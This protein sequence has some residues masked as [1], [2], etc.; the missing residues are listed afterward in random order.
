M[1]KGDIIEI[2]ITDMTDDGKGVGHFD[3][4]AVFTDGAVIGDTV[5]A[6][7]NK[8][9]KNYSFASCLEIIEQSK[10]RRKDPCPYIKTCGGCAYGLL[11]HDAQLELKRSHVE[12][13]LKRLGGIA[14]PKV[15]EIVPSD[16]PFNY[17]NKAVMAVS[18]EAVGFNAR[19]SHDVTDCLDCELQASPAMAAASSLRS[20]IK[21]DHIKDLVNRLTVK[22]AFDTGEVM[23]IFDIKSKGIPNFEKLVDI[24]DEA[25]SDLPPNEG[26][27]YS[28]ESV[29]LID[30]NGKCTV[31]AG[32][33]T[34]KDVICGLTFEISPLSFYQ[35][36]PRQAE[37]LYYKVA[38][39]AHIKGGENILDLYCGVGTIGLVL[40]A[41]QEDKLG[42][43]VGVESVHEAVIT[44]NRNAVVNRIV[45]AVYYEGLAEEIIE[46]VKRSEFEG[47]DIDLVILDPP[48]RGCDEKLLSAVTEADPQKI[49]YVSCDPATMSRD[50]KYLTAN[51]YK[52]EECT[53]FDMFPH[54]GEVECCTLLA[55]PS[56]SEG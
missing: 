31:P 16:K 3:G 54:T 39:Y 38:E 46:D 33:K 20:F 15:N 36:N 5:K 4:I 8:V 2:K 48:R 17:R 28:L 47:K 29:A 35:V 11:S 10:Y 34:I 50:I 30:K 55:K 13:K 18:G 42:K 43:I 12:Q 44:A 9:K 19:R 24:L 32:T 23:A 6:E 51:G 45:N 26:V 41:M 53:P 27:E 14:S 22:T 25:V 52:F 40:A 7:V 1:N 56:V 37:K 49:I 21:S